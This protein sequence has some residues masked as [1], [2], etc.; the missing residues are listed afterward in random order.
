MQPDVILAGPSS[1][2]LP[3]QRLTQTIPI[4]FVAVSDPL[5][6]GIVAS[7]ARP[8][9]N[10]TGFSNLEFSLAGKWLRL[11]KDVAPSVA[12]VVVMIATSNAVSGN[13]FQTFGELAPTFGIE[14]LP[15][16]IRE[17]A[18]I[19]RSIEALARQPNGGLIRGYVSRSAVYAA[20]H[21]QARAST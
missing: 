2:L 17:H 5:G 7:L 20:V 19:E 11:L 1:A 14:V 15:A 10:I 6:Q 18:D 9:G 3:L 12:R 16:P 21:Y 8:T 13:W 4:V